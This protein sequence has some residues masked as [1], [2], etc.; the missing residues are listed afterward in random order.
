M[1]N[2]LPT[3]DFSIKKQ[4]TPRRKAVNYKAQVLKR[5][6]F[7]EKSSSQ[8]ILQSSKPRSTKKTENVEDLSSWMCSVCGVARVEDMRQCSTCKK[9]VHEDCV[10][11]T[12]KDRDEFEC[13]NCSP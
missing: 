10:G 9:W 4:L 6:L 7:S 1:T 2:L 12:T 11:L 13:P 3:P 5:D 8:R